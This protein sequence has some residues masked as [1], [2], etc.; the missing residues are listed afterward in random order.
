[1][2]NVS[3]PGFQNL[4]PKLIVTLR[5]EYEN[6]IQQHPDTDVV[7]ERVR[8]VLASIPR[9]AGCTPASVGESPKWTLIVQNMADIRRN[10]HQFLKEKQLHS[11]L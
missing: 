6:S 7:M 10:I 3:T 2:A 8:G 4:W 1:M 9:L 11:A 5:L